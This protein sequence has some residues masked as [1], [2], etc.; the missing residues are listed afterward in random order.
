MAS[1]TLSYSI[2]PTVQVPRV[3]P[4]R[5]PRKRM[6][7]DTSCREHRTHPPGPFAFLDGVTSGAPG[8]Q[9]VRTARHPATHPAVRLPC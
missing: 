3:P 8:C 5:V 4:W 6:A 9:D 2:P 7:H 1:E